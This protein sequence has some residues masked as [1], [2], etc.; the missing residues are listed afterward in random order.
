MWFCNAFP[1]S[2]ISYGRTLTKES[3]KD[4]IKVLKKL[5]CWRSCERVCELNPEINAICLM[6]R[7]NQ[8]CW[9]MYLWFQMIKMRW[10]PRGYFNIQTNKISNKTFSDMFCFYLPKL[11]LAFVMKPDWHF[12]NKSKKNLLKIEVKGPQVNQP[13]PVN[14][15]CFS[16]HCYDSREGWKTAKHVSSGLKYRISR[17]HTK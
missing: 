13:S 8:T 1:V 16:K 9:I 12:D 10:F 14:D 5:S 3:W 6:L 17:L 11:L 7:P 4:T 15:K 2:N